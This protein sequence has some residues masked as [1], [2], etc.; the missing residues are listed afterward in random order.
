MVLAAA[1]WLSGCG[2]KASAQE[3]EG[4]FSF[5]FMSDLQADP[6]TG[7]YS[8]IGG[9]LDK[10]LAHDSQPR[11]LVLGGDS[12]NDG[13]SAAEWADF[14]AAAGGRLDGVTVATAAGNHDSAPLLAEQ[15]DYPESAPAASTEGYFYTFTEGG[16]FFLML[17]SNI[18]GGGN[19]TH[20]EWIKEQLASD[21]AKGANWRIAVTHHPLWPAAEIPKDVQRAETMRE[22]FLPLMSSGDVDVLLCG[23]QHMYSL[24]APVPAWDATESNVIQVM[25]ASGG[26]GSYKAANVD[27]IETAAEAPNYIIAEADA[28]TLNITAFDKEGAAFDV[29]QIDKSE[30]Q[31]KF[32]TR[33]SVLRKGAQGQP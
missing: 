22:V 29:I 11:L 19:A 33:C 32:T 7:D 8:A 30:G 10:A 20:A 3:T 24:A 13:S 4:P 15:F 1:L 31:K 21:A 27:Y 5:I 12:V 14:W 28:K 23:H 18:M 2:A 16:A 26:K 6:E 25:A 9:L 17:D